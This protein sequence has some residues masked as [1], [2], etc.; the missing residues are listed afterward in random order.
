MMKK[1]FA[2]SLIFHIF[3]SSVAFAVDTGNLNRD[4]G[5][6]WSGYFGQKGNAR[7]DLQFIAA[8]IRSVLQFLTSIAKINVLLP[9]DLTGNVNVK[10]SDIPLGDALH[11]I[12]RAYDLEYTID[13]G[14]MRIGKSDAFKETGEDLKTE[15]FRLKFATASKTQ[16]KVAKLLTTR[17]SV[18]ADDR[19]NSL[20]VRE[21]PA[22]MDSIRRFVNDIDIKDAQVLIESK[23]LEATR[24]FS[25]SLGIQWGVNKG[26]GSTLVTGLSNVG[27]A[28]SGRTLQGNFPATAPT[29]GIGLIIGSLAQGTNIDVQISAA[30]TRGDV[31]VISDPSVVTS[32][33]MA[34]RIRSGTTLLVKGVGNVTIS[35]S[36]ASSGSTGTGI[37]QIETGIELNVTP[38]ITAGDFVKLTI[39]AKT[40][41][42]DYAQAVDGIPV[43]VAN[44]TVTTVVVKDGETTVI[45]GLS[46]Y[47]DGLQKKG[48]P[49]FSKI[50]LLGNLFKSKD[51]NKSNTEMMIFIKPNVVRSEGQLPAQVR[52]R[53]IEAQRERMEINPVLPSVK[54]PEEKKPVI[55]DPAS[56]QWKNKFN[57]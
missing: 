34:A 31:Y 42:P 44:E 22:Y 43:I 28:Q 10:L 16:D 38:Q 40:S 45:G 47:S 49:G 26:G 29:S 2:M 9:E 35:N 17:G 57:K 14:V 25:R 33:G 41:T 19:T 52:V 15:I 7:F 53:E 21:I 11:A 1:I 3:L 36:G 27:V 46:R 4:R 8:D 23:I 51:I 18:I 20:I 6:G 32:N 54:S 13:N 48:V 55:K 12:I 37:E 30:E 50:P 24:A 5:E 56:D 39:E